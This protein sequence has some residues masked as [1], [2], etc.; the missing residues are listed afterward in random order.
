MTEARSIPAAPA[1]LRRRA[2]RLLGALPVAACALAA[3][4]SAHEFWLMPETFE[5]A[6]GVP[7]GVRLFVGDGFEKGQPYPRNPLHIKEFKA[8]SKTVSEI[9][10]SP[11]A[12]P[13]GRFTPTAPG[14]LALVYRSTPSEL[15]LAAGRFE[16]YLRAE[17]LEHVSRQRAAAGASAEPGR[18]AF[19][20]CAKSL[21][22]VAGAGDE[23]FD[24]RVGLDLEIVPLEPPFE[25][26]AGA[27]LPLLVLWQGEPVSGARLRAFVEG[28]PELTT[29]LRTGADGTAVVTVAGP[30]VWMLSTVHMEPAA[31]DSGVDWQ[32]TWSSLTFRT[33]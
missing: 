25:L 20:R 4:A 33:R 9:G 2:R 16:A 8:V 31:P 29:E 10:G 18:E 17:G 26:Q 21:V 24:R 12:D 32:S 3:P 15:T 23:G 13:A 27:K 28:R 11:G 6:V 5:P 14:V 30:G 7:S 19:S 22:R 1:A